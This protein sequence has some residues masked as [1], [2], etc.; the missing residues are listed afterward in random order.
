MNKQLLLARIQ[1]LQN[2]DPDKEITR[3]QFRDATG[4][5]DTVWEKEFG[6]FTEFKSAAGV[7]YGKVKRTLQYAVAKHSAVDSLRDLTKTKEGYEGKYLKP[8]GERFQTILTGSDIHDKLCDPFYR[9]MFIEAATR[10]QP[11]KIILAGDIFDMY[12]ISKYGQ[13]P[14]K[15]NILESIRW[16]HAF[17]NDLRIKSPNSE[18]I[19][20]SGNHENRLLR[21]LSEQAPSILPILSDLHG[22]TIPGLLGLDEYE[23]NFISKD[24]LAVFTETDLKKEIGKNYYLAYDAVL[25]HH[26][27]YASK[28]GYPGVN[29]HH[30]NHKVDFHFTPRIGSYEW[31]QL[32]SGHIRNAGFTEGEKWSNGFALIHVDTVSKKV[33]F[34]YLDVSH[35]HCVFGGI[36]YSR[37]EDELVR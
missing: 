25:F 13:D 21:Y 17:L 9:R 2:L 27:P 16:V 7:S 4:I 12:E 1:E 6:T 15:I 10:V 20:V 33:Q 26:F 31:H 35:I 30:H 5:S 29:G 8:S 37:N 14:R 34:E 22:L 19:L 3:K 23:V 11:Q 36:W 24:T 28:W 32:G 18:I